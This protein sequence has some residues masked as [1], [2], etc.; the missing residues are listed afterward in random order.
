[1]IMRAFLVIT[2][3]ISSFF[4]PGK[5]TAKLEPPADSVRESYTFSRCA[6][7]ALAER[8]EPKGKEMQDAFKVDSLDSKKDIFCGVYDGHG[9]KWPSAYA[10][11]Q[12]HGAL[13]L[14]A[15][16][17]GLES[18]SKIFKRAFEKINKTII[19]RNFSKGTT[20]AVIWL[21]H[22]YLYVANLGD[23][24]II[25]VLQNGKYILAR[26]HTASCLEERQ[27]V[28]R[29]G[30]EIE[31][32]NN[33]TPY[34]VLPRRRGPNLGLR[35]SRTL[36]DQ[37]FEKIGKISEP[38]VTRYRASDVAHVVLMSDGIMNAI[39]RAWK[40]SSMKKYGEL[41][42][43]KADGIK[44]WISLEVKA[45]SEENCLSIAQ[46]MLEF[47]L[48]SYEKGKAD[49]MTVLILSMSCDKE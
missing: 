33:E 47:A 10:R 21:R 26:E 11:D 12:L 1:M 29:S 18:F 13:Y 49:D 40:L 44:K 5:A 31:E 4:I 22:D 30:G 43:N 9:G 37:I 19:D 28:K 16:M 14:Q 42:G 3:L 48:N 25:V 23:S 24:S 27:R 39:E 7:A 17:K 46:N 41:K 8:G 34:I 32:V 45:L 20:A 38:T 6:V 35:P 2:I 36:G 15:H